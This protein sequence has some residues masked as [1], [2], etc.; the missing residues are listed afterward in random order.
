MDRK[1]CELVGRVKSSPLSYA[2]KSGVYTG[3]DESFFEGMEQRWIAAMRVDR[4]DRRDRVFAEQ[5]RQS[6]NVADG[7]DVGGVLI[8]EVTQVVE[9]MIALGLLG[10][11]EEEIPPALTEKYRDYTIEPPNTWK[12][13]AKMG[14]RFLVRVGKGISGPVVVLTDINDAQGVSLHENTPIYAIDEVV[15]FSQEPIEPIEE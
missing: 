9:K 4:L 12:T 11:E 8:D 7:L 10:N 2:I 14:D 6:Y 1:L 13:L 3:F 5:C 15:K